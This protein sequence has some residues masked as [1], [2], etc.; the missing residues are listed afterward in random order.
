MGRLLK[1]VRLLPRFLERILQND[2]CGSYLLAFD[3][4]NFVDPSFDKVNFV[5][6]PFDKVNFVA[7]SFDKVNFSCSSVSSFLR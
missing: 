2:I 1:K 5:D 4:V 6:H 3:K 7:P